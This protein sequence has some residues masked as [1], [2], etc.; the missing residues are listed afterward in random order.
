M[1]ST[2]AIAWISIT[3]AMMILSISKPPANVAIWDFLNGLG[4][5]GFALVIGGC[6][7]GPASRAR[8]NVRALHLHT[9]IATIA[10]IA[11]C[12][13]T[14]GMIATNTVA[15]E[16][17]KWRAP[18]YMHAGNLGLLLLIFLSFTS[19]G[20]LRRRLHKSFHHFRALHRALSAV[21]I[22]LCAWHVIGSGYLTAQLWKPLALGGIVIATTAVWWWQPRRPRWPQADTTEAVIKWSWVSSLAVVFFS[23][24]YA[25]VL[26]I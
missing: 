10:L 2:G 8:Y 25:W 16:Y 4:V 22:A 14:L 15:V 12:A 26:A 6:W 18:A 9:L 23:G 13:H 20:R 1:V 17:L 5:A 7:I 24:L 11:I 19:V 21:A 3:V